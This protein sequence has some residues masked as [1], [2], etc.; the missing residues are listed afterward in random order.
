MMIG[1]GEI[2]ERVLLR[3]RLFVESG[4]ELRWILLTP[5][6]FADRGNRCTSPLR[7]LVRERHVRSR[8]DAIS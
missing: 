3:V 7:C 1:D 5:R 2:A 4:C 8:C 6:H